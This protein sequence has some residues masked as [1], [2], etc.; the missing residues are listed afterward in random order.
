MSFWD[1][2]GISGVGYDALEGSDG[3][4]ERL[5][6]VQGRIQLGK[7]QRVKRT[8]LVMGVER[9]HIWVHVHY[10]MNAWT[11]CGQ[12]DIQN[13][14][15]VGALREKP[16]KEEGE[17]RLVGEME[18]TSHM[19]EKEKGN[20]T[21]GLIT[22]AREVEGVLIGGTEEWRPMYWMVKTKRRVE[23]ARRNAKESERPPLRGC[24]GGLSDRN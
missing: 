15:L 21:Q 14:L 20:E 4:K 23:K 10:I 12:G 13:R 22:G 17:R 7:V 19:N 8:D 1:S 16:V 24:H 18:T 5:R 6:R 3:E 11:F 2:W 9:G